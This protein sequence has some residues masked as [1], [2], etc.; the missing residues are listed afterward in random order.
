[1]NYTYEKQEKSCVKFT[2]TFEKEDFD[3]AI[4]AAYQKNKNKFN[5]PGFR[6]GHVPF[7][8]IV[9]QYGKEYFYEDAINIAISEHYP[10][11]LKKEEGSVKAV[12]DP[13]FSL[14]SIDENGFV[15][16]AIVPV[17][18][19]FELGAYKGIKIE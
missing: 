14:E 15:L 17:M 18:P 3:K 12:G 7:H 9:G 6:K 19:E 2:I 8:V 5:V 11:I 16:T 4:S 10:E 1:M 13:D